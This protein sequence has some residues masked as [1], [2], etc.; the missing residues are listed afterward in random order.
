[1]P[2]VPGSVPASK[3][4]LFEA[5]RAYLKATGRRNEQYAEAARRFLVRWPDVAAWAGRP[6]A[7]RLGGDDN[8]RPFVMFLMLHGHLRPGY[9]FLLARRKLPSLWRELPHSPMAA[10]IGRFTRAAAAAGFTERVTSGTASQVIARLL[11]QTGRPLAELTTADFAE[12][13]AAC[14]EREQRDGTGWRHYSKAIYA[15]RQVLFHMGV[16]DSAPPSYWHQLRQSFE[17]RLADVPAALRPSLVAYLDRLTATHSRQSVTGTATRLAHFGRHLAAV[18]P[19]VTSLA[20][21]DRRRHIETYLTAVAEARSSR[22]GG[23]LSASERRGRVL[24]VSVMLNSIT[25]WGW[26]EAPPRRLVFRSDIPKLPRPLPRYLPPDADRR[27]AAAL[28]DSPNRLAAGALL[29]QR[30]CGLRIGELCDLE[31][32]CAHEVPGQGAWLKVPLGKLD[33]ERMVPLDDE[34]VAIVDRIVAHRSRGAPIPHPRTGKRTEFLLTHHGRRLSPPALRDELARAAEAAGIGHVTPHALRHTYATALVNSGVSLQSLMALLGHV[35]AEMSLRYGR[36]FDQTVRAEYER[37]LTL[38]KQ[39]IGS[40]PATPPAAGRTALPLLDGDW[41]QAP[42]IKARLAGGYCLRAQAQGACQY[43]NIC[44]HC[45]NFRADASHLAV[46]AAQRV[47]A[48]A[49]AADA[50][51]R[52]WAAEATRHR[53]LAER[54]GAIITQAQAG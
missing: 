11:I 15:A 43:A 19:Q 27:L 51:A 17:Q 46:L 4:E 37:A 52:G 45:P 5:F 14:Q 25:E 42:A 20:Q 33:T 22:G 44:E 39:Q 31:L 35:S 54:L 8:Q 53:L 41:K 26:P 13:A 2:R 49:L 9:D 7:S 10:D 47:D 21:L 29:L 34:A 36:L 32:D 28:E 12:L 18:D 24:A 48:E 40:L 3:A 16:L 23:P 50:A 1:M 30:A 6:L 38:A